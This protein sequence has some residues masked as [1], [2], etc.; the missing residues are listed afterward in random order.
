MENV[1][2]FPALIQRHLVDS[3]KS[4]LGIRN[5][6]SHWEANDL[7]SFFTALGLWFKPSV[8]KSKQAAR[9]DAPVPGC[10]EPR[11][12]IRP[13]SEPAQTAW[14]S[15]A[16][17]LWILSATVTFRAFL[18]RAGSGHQ[19]GLRTRPAVPAPP[20]PALLSSDPKARQLQGSF[21]G[22]PRSLR[23]FI[24]LPARQHPSFIPDGCDLPLPPSPK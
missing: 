2:V 23:G 19:R 5:Y 18:L 4:S 22:Y 15:S 9:S 16:L 1:G 10:S 17:S 13:K 20:S 3:S 7:E 11:D 6:S 24:Q 8:S 12:R 14:F 21:P